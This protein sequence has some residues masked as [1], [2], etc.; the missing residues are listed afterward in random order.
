MVLLSL[1]LLRIQ[2]SF[3]LDFLQWNS[4]LSAPSAQFVLQLT[5]VD[6]TGVFAAKTLLRTHPLQ[7]LA[8]AGAALLPVI[9]YAVSVADTLGCTALPSDAHCEPLSFVQVC[10]GGLTIGRCSYN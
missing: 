2:P 7:L 9:A 1:L 6:Q 5:A 8:G 10:W 3:L 4:R